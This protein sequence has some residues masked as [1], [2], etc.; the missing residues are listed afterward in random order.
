MIEASP[1]VVCKSRVW[2]SIDHA[3]HKRAEGSAKSGRGSRYPAGN[4]PR[5]PGGLP[6]QERLRQRQARTAGRR[7]T[8]TI[9]TR[10]RSPS[11]RT[12]P[13]N[14]RRGQHL[15]PHPVAACQA[16]AGFSKADGTPA[17]VRLHRRRQHLGSPLR[18][19][20]G[21]AHRRVSGADAYF[22]SDPAMAWDNSGNAYAAYMLLSNNSGTAPSARPSSLPSQAI[23]GPIGRT[24]GPWST[25]SPP[26]RPSTT[27]RCWPSTTPASAPS[28][29]PGASMSSGTP[30]TSATRPSRTTASPGRPTSSAAPAPLG[31]ADIKVGPD[32]TVYVVWNRV[33]SPNNL[34]QAQG[35]RHLLQP[36]PP[37]AGSHG[38]RRVKDFAAPPAPPGPISTPAGGAGRSGGVNSFPALDIDRRTPSS[39]VLQRLSSRLRRRHH[40]LLPLNTSADRRPRARSSSDGRR[41]LEQPRQGQRRYSRHHPH[42]PPGRGPV[43][44]HGQHRLVRHRNDV[45]QER[46][47]IFLNARSVNGGAT[48]QANINLTDGS[49]N[50]NNLV[51]Y[52]NEYSFTNIKA[53]PNQYPATTWGLAATN[54]KVAAA[55]GL[56]PASSSGDDH[57]R[58]QGRHRRRH[59][60][61]LLSQPACP[62][63]PHRHDLR[64]HRLLGRADLGR[65]ATAAPT[66]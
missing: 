52:N 31:G 15:L 6:R 18:P 41:T 8:T 57:Q 62:C 23:P 26:P 7:R 27:R 54:R 14:G 22:G 33:Y 61:Q 5:R 19:L 56:T 66:P 55:C 16:P 24:W 46:T 34:G 35:G 58:P 40:H 17:L 36:I 44:R 20:A 11:I 32:G 25:T 63:Q 51:S 65:H 42:L 53:N 48:F 30:T 47:Q 45:N 49:A 39:P 29:T 2:R 9:R 37:T 50:F 28:R 59:L 43:R 3:V 10:C 38:P 1:V 21:H 64:R 60:H 4:R 12:T 13:P